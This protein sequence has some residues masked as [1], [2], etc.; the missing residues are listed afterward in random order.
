MNT[1]QPSR[2]PKNPPRRRE[3]RKVFEIAFLRALRV[4]AVKISL[5]AGQGFA[6][7]GHFSLVIFHL[8][9]VL[10]ARIVTE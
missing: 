8:S 4:F 7:I 1:V 10:P 2:N 5:T 9:F 3:E 6:R